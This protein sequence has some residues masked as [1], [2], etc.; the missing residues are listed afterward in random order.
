MI[1]L[2][3]I[4]LTALTATLALLEL[5]SCGESEAPGPAAPY[6]PQLTI[7]VVLPV[8]GA[9]GVST[10]PALTAVR[11]AEED[12]R[13]AGGTVEFRYADSGSDPA[14]ASRAVDALLE[15]GANAILGA[16]ASGVSQAFIETLHERRV[17]QCTYSNTSPSFT[18]QPNAAY[19]FRTVTPDTAVADLIGEMIL[20]RG[21]QRVSILAR[22]DDYGRSFAN[23]LQAAL[24]ERGAVAEAI[25][26]DPLAADFGR[27]VEAVARYAPDAVAI[28]AF[29]EG[30]AL[31]RGLLA[32]GFAPS[33][34][35]G[36]DGLYLPD[37]PLAVDEA[38]PGVLD[39]MTLSVAGAPDSPARAAFSERLL[40]AG[41][42]GGSPWAARA[43]DCAVILALAAR[44]A[45]STDGVPV[46]AAV[47]EVTNGGTECADYED[48]ARRI[49][50]GE[51]VAY[52]GKAG[53]LRLDAAGGA[54]VAI[55]T[56]S[57]YEGG[58]LTEQSPVTF[59]LA[60]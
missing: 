49:D 44:A 29:E 21:A 15:E 25:I 5:A 27:E 48:C 9:L 46:F 56:V 53:P 28:A 52:T 20:A 57:R 26:F 17:Q 35:Y 3:R 58:A 11:L 45:G 37:L 47:L 60:R 2:R 23:L 8:T 14:T 54:T 24:G 41:A 39:G 59:D 16:A 13:A 12:I 42:N 36:T 33:S 30:A 31:L 1:S 38:S 51:D 50:T 19:Y 55:Y 18:T 22:D 34:L 43:Y 10:T 32:A 6:Q 7:G 4:A 40:R